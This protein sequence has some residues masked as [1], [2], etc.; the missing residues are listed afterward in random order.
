MTAHWGGVKMARMLPRTVG[1]CDTLTRLMMLVVVMG[2]WAGCASSVSP[3]ALLADAEG[4]AGEGK[5]AMHPSAEPK[6]IIEAGDG[7]E[8]L[9]QRGAGEEKY[10]DPVRA[11]RTLSVALLHTAVEGAT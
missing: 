1:Q 2:L 11:N 3:D 5:G 6:E 4:R 7:L 9:S 10:T 8:L